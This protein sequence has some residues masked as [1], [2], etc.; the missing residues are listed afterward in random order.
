MSD[1]FSKIVRPCKT[2]RGWTYCSI[3]FIDGRLSIT[4]VEGPRKDGDCAGSCGQ[5]VMSEWDVKEYGKGWD[6]DSVVKFREIWNRWHLNDMCAGSPKQEEFLRQ[7]PSERR[8]YTATCKL[9]EEAGLLVDYGYKY[10]SAW[11]SEQAPSD[12]LD[13]LKALPVSPTKPAWV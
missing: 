6:A 9:L 2:E 4:G 8:D 7:H 5:I 1:S 3:K 13:W 12:V 11:L 10:G